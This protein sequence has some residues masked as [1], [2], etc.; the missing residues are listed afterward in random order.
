LISIGFDDFSEGV[1]VF[2]SKLFFRSDD[3]RLAGGVP[4][5]GCFS[6]KIDPSSLRN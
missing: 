2:K 6:M 1:T 3:E 5:A 4:T